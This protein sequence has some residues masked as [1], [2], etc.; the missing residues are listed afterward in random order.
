MGGRRERGNKIL[1]RIFV[2]WLSKTAP[3]HTGAG[4]GVSRQDTGRVKKM[5]NPYAPGDLKGPWGQV[6]RRFSIRAYY[7]NSVTITQG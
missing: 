1:C 2:E 3:A 5:L 4:I 6:S 7:N